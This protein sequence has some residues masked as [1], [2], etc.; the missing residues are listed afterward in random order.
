M[1]ILLA[2]KRVYQK[3]RTM[4]SALYEKVKRNPRSLAAEMCAAQKRG[5]GP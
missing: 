3:I 5:G 1:C 2:G 4:L